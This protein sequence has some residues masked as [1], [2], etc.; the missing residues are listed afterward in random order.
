MDILK[1]QAQAG[2]RP[3]DTLK[4]TAVV[5]VPM[6]YVLAYIYSLDFRGEWD[7]LF[8]KGNQA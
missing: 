5:S 3:W 4:G 6:H 1:R 7:E 8:V 2:E